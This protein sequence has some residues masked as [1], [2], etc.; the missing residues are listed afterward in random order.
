MREHARQNRFYITAGV[1]LL[2]L[3]GMAWIAFASDSYATERDVEWGQYQNSPTNNGV[4]GEIETPATYNETA[5][6][7]SR[8]AAPDYRRI[9]V[10]RLQHP[11]VPDQQK[12]RGGRERE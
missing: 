1:V 11:C 7:W 5:L 9:S 8:Y 10:H 12:H 6:K 4:I 3:L 2:L